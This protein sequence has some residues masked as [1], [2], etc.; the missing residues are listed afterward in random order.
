MVRRLR[1][2]RTLGQGADALEFFLA[3]LQVD[4]INDRLALAISQRQLDAL[5]SVVSIMMGALI[6]RINR[7]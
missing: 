4:R 2:R 1:P 3:V 5:G 6:L 7:S